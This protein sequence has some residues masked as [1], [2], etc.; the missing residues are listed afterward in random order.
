MANNDTITASTVS[1]VNPSCASEIEILRRLVRTSS[2]N[3]TLS[4]D[5]DLV[6]LAY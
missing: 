3:L 2:G 5:F 6:F 1:T 4:V